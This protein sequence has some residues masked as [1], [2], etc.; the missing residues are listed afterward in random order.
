MFTIKLLKQNTYVL[1]NLHIYDGGGGSPNIAT[2]RLGST[3]VYLLTYLLTY[4][5]TQLS[6]FKKGS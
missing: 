1:L 3:Y 4:F 5:S 6:N 2:L